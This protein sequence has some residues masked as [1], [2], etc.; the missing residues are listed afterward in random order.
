MSARTWRQE[1]AAPPVASDLQITPVPVD[2]GR[3]RLDLSLFLSQGERLAGRFRYNRDVLD[4]PRV[5]ALRDRYLG[6]LAK[7]VADPDCPLAEL[8]LRS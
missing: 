5:A 2:T 8:A 1:A 6:I 3:I 7:A 4:A